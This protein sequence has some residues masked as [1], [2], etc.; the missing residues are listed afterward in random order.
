MPLAGLVSQTMRSWLSLSALIL[1]GLALAGCQAG[2]AVEPSKHSRAAT[3]SVSSTGWPTRCIE[4]PPC[5]YVSPD[6]EAA[7]PGT[8]LVYRGL[9]WRARKPV[10]ATFGSYCPPTANACTLVGYSR[11][12]R[13]NSKGRFWFRFVEAPKL[14]AGVPEPA[15]SGRGPVGFEQWSGR[16]YKSRLIQRDALSIPRLGSARD[17]ADARALRSITLR[18]ERHIRRKARGIS[19]ELD[20]HEAAVH[21]CRS[22][23]NKEEPAEVAAVILRV[24]LA[25]SNAV[26]HGP[27][28]GGLERFAASIEQVQ[29]ADS[30][31]REGAAAWA[32][33][34]RAPRY[35]PRPTVCAVLRRWQEQGY[36]ASAA[37]VTKDARELRDDVQADGR[38]RAAARRMRELGSG[39]RAAEMFG[40]GFLEIALLIGES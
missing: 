23:V 32:A 37:P 20:R 8:L 33:H 36:A 11:R 38:I 30:A 17:R 15:A 5:A 21:R 4:R 24:V 7:D 35:E 10:D 14:P 29:P 27:I 22:I 9:G 6:P 40:G 13:A 12:L 3:P 2:S 34:I 1:C 39:K 31:L 28:R 16:A 26:L 25:G 18:L 19:R